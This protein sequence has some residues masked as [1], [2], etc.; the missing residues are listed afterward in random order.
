MKGD[1]SRK[2][3]GRVSESTAQSRAGVPF[4]NVDFTI[5]IAVFVKILSGIAGEKNI[6]VK[7]RIGM[8]VEEIYGNLVI[9]CILEE[10]VEKF[11]KIAGS[12]CGFCEI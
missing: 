9:S 8:P 11:N 12:R 5:G 7:S 2:N 4:A 3:V 6:I 1:H 10:F